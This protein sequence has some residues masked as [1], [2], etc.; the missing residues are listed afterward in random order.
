MDEMKY[1]TILD[2]LDLI[3]LLLARR[4]EKVISTIDSALNFF[5]EFESVTNKDIA[6]VLDVNPRA[7]ANARA[8][9]GKK[10]T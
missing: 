8:K 7:V 3:V 5:G 4:D 2:R 6:R 10:R 1:K 9:K